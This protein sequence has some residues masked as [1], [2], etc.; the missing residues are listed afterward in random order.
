MDKIAEITYL[1]CKD[2]K[3]DDSLS[4]STEKPKKKNKKGCC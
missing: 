3:K 4:L 1:I 2:E